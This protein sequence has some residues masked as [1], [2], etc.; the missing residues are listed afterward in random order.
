MKRTLV[1]IALMGIVTYSL[2]W[3]APSASKTLSVSAVISNHSPEMD[4]TI[5]KFTDGNPDNNPWTNSTDVTS[6]MNLDFGTLVHTYVEG[7]VTKDYG[8]WISD[9]GFAVIVYTQ[10]FGTKYEVRSSCAGVGTLPA[11]GFGVTPVYSALDEWVWPDGSRHQQGDKPTAAVLG[12]DGTAI[13]TN[14][15]VY[16]SESPSTARIIQVY[17]GMPPKKA[18]GSVPFSGWTGIP[19]TQAAG[20]YTGTVTLSIVAI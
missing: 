13:A 19:L 9:A 18:D 7:G 14:K 12:T 16:T 1:V 20:T 8:V 10:G 4:I 15:A 3:A 5:L 6:T 17:Y 11:G 2:C